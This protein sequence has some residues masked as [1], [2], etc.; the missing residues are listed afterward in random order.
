MLELKLQVTGDRLQGYGLELLQNPASC[1]CEESRCFCGTTKQSLNSCMGATW[2]VA[3]S[4][5]KSWDCA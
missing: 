5:H 1:H 3:C 2:Q 4:D